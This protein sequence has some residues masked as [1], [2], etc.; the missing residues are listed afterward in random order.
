[1][2]GIGDSNFEETFETYSKPVGNGRS[3]GPRCT[4][5]ILE[6]LR[7]SGVIVVKPFL[8]IMV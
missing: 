5:R 3:G 8:K 6:V 2:V 1:M 4:M 7:I